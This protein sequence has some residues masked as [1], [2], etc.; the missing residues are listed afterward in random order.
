MEE[1]MTIDQVLAVTIDILE[2][3]DVPMKKLETIGI[4]IQRAVGNLRLCIQAVQESRMPKPAE[5]APETAEL[6]EEKPAEAAFPEVE[7]E[8]MIIEPGK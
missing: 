6:P 2:G 5:A 1:R 3:I 8:E 4:P 7:C